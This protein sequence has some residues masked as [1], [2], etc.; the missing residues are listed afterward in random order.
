MLSVVT[1][2][3][4][5][6]DVDG[7]L[8]DLLDDA[9]RNLGDRQPSAALL[10]AAFDMDHQKLLSGINQAWPGLTLIGGTTDGEISNALPF[11]EDSTVLMLFCSELVDITAGLGRNLGKDMVTACHQALDEARAGTEKVPALCIT[12]PESV[13][14]DGQTLVETFTGILGEQDV[15]LLGATTADQWQFTGSKQFFGAEVVSDSLP[16]LLFS[17]P[18]AYSYAVASGWKGIGEPGIV[19]RS[20]G[21]VVYEVDG[22]PAIEF[23]RKFLGDHA[24]PSGSIPLALLD[25]QGRIEALRA[26]PGIVDG[27]TGS[28]TFLAHVRQ[29]ARVQITVADRDSILDGCRTSTQQA[30]D[31]FPNDKQPQAALFFSC[32]GRRMLLGTRVREEGA[33][34]RDVLGEDL[35]HGGFYGYGEIAPYTAEDQRARFHN[36]SFIALLLGE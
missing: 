7:A 27:E 6:P 8:D 9:R 28:I 33:I 19:T 10:L 25:D 24:M 1:A 18:L 2:H 5:D 23:Y 13:G 34:I 35:P 17:G 16:I 21:P 4:E 26:P 31:R 36:E 12:V 22:A 32:A 14:L 20:E 29:G 15:P 30:H 11:A 3:S